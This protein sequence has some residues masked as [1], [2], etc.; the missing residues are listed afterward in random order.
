MIKCLKKTG[1]EQSITLQS[2]LSNFP[3]DFDSIFLVVVLNLLRLTP[4]PVLCG[5][6]IVSKRKAHARAVFIIIYFI[7]IKRSFTEL[8]SS[9]FLTSMSKFLNLG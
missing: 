2:S 6:R 5:K 4:L 8:P 1:K 9:S 3:H 7:V